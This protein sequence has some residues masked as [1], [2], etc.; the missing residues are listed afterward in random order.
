MR[1]FSLLI[2]RKQVSLSVKVHSSDKGSF[3]RRQ[4]V[5]FVMVNLGPME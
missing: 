1:V 3:L 2:R 4:V 5:H